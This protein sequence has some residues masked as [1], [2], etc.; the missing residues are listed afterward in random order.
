MLAPSRI[1]LYSVFRADEINFILSSNFKRRNNCGDI[2]WGK[3]ESLLWRWLANP[4]ENILEL[5]QKWRL[6][7]KQQGNEE[8]SCIP[9]YEKPSTSFHSF[10]W[11]RGWQVLPACLA[12]LPLSSILCLLGISDFGKLW[13]WNKLWKCPVVSGR[14]NAGESRLSVALFA[15]VWLQW[16]W[17][18]LYFYE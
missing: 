9:P 18:T 1:S 11:L 4:S 15:P 13:R 14:L 3:E 2:W 7:L 17:H 10:L 16:Q 6:F 12:F 5:S 8:T